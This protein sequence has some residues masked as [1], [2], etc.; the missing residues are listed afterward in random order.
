VAAVACALTLPLSA[1]VRADSVPP[2][3]P[4]E[5]GIQDVEM[6]VGQ[7][8]SL[9]AQLD[10]DDPQDR[11]QARQQLSSIS[12]DDLP[13]LKSAAEAEAP[14]SPEQIEAVRDITLQT[15]LTMPLPDDSILPHIPPR[16]RLGIYWNTGRAQECDR[17]VIVD[18]RFTAESYRK[19]QPGD[20]IVSLVGGPEGPLN[21]IQLVSWI[22]RMQPGE[23]VHLNVLR[24]G[25]LIGVPV[26][27]ASVPQQ[28]GEEPN[29]VQNLMQRRLRQFQEYW[30]AQWRDLGPGAEPR[31]N[32]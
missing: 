4:S 25:Q 11:E 16:G 17:G 19:L 1:A 21:F 22:N 10:S 20:I 28:L 5:A 3:S 15:F 7:M 32:P 8:R 24:G 26:V 27:L 9:I 18:Q 30:N 13:V 2:P 14:L 12:I 23:T 29:A 6:S 31:T